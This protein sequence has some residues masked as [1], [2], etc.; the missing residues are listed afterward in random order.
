MAGERAQPKQAPGCC[1]AGCRRCDLRG[2]L[3][4]SLSSAFDRFDDFLEVHG[5]RISLD[6]VELL[7]QAAG[8][9]EPERRLIVERV[10]GLQPPNKAPQAGAVLLGILVGLF[11]AQFE[12][13]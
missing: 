8:V 11:A 6:G 10:V 3:Y 1:Q 9:R 12:N 7:Q 5:A 2:V 13:A 4:D